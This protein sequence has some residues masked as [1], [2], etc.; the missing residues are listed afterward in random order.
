[1]A[2]VIHHAFVIAR[3]TTSARDSGNSSKCSSWLAIRCLPGRALQQPSVNTKPVRPE[4]SLPI[5]GPGPS[6][7]INE[8]DLDWRYGAAWPEE[9]LID[10]DVGSN[11]GNW[12]Y[13]A[14]VGADPRGLRQ[15]NLDKQTQ[16]YDPTG[17]FVDHWGGQAEQ[18]VG[19]HTVDAADWPLL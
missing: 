3:H 12:Q 2:D 19:L 8:P 18:P 16:Q 7:R 10:Y 6:C 4:T 17:T 1:M 9:Q 14:G 15:F 13:L 5:G 11:Y